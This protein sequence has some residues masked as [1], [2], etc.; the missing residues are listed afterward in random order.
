MKK[1]HGFEKMKEKLCSPKLLIHT[2]PSFYRLGTFSSHT[3][4]DGSEKPI[5]YP[6]RTLSSFEQNYSQI[7]KKSLAIIFAIKKCHQYIL[8]W[9]IIIVTN[10]KPILSILSEKKWIPKLAASRFVQ[11]C[12]QSTI[13]PWKAKQGHL[14]V[15]L[16][17]SVDFLKT[18]KMTS[19]N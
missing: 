16:I 2:T 5:L 7:E 15:M 3:L 11:L 4:P 17:A 12:F 13:I 14:I 10:N 19:Q 8:G 1:K 18:V 6:S 9:R